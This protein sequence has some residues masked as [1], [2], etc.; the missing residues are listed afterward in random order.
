[1]NKIR[2]LTQLSD[3]DLLAETNA[4]AARERTATARLIAALAEIDGRRLYLRQAC[5]SMF[6]YCTEMLHLS[7]YAAYSRIEAARA[8]RRFPC[9]LTLLEDGAITLTTIGLLAAHLT[10]KNHEQV[11]ASAT[12]KSKRLVEELVAALKPQASVPA[13]VRKLPSPASA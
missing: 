8:A 5:R 7:E 10:D 9:L 3:P 1:M 11:L 4:L 6:T 13:V 12:L 2:A